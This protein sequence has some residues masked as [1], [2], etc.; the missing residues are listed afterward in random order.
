MLKTLLLLFVA[1]AVVEGYGKIYFLCPPGYYNN[2]QGQCI[3]QS[4]VRNQ[5]KPIV[6]SRSAPNPLQRA[7]INSE[8]V[9]SMYNTE[10]NNDVVVNNYH[11]GGNPNY[12]GNY[13]PNGGVRNQVANLAHSMVDRVHGLFSWG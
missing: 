9:D 12:Q 6:T 4:I 7:Q 1:L 11:Y 5:E 2:N 13:R 3:H 8:A 10:N